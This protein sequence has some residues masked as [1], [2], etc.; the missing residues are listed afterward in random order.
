[1]REYDCIVIGGGITGAGAVRDAALRGLKVLLI[2]KGEL[3]CG[4]TASSS[5]LLH[6][7][8]RYLAYDRTTTQM[9]CWDSGNILRIARSL[10]QRQVFLWPVYRHHKHRME[11]VESLLEAYDLLQP[12]KEGKKHLRLDAPATLSILPGL[13]SQG[14]LGSLTFDEWW[15][16]PL[17]LVRQ[18]VASAQKY[19]AEV[20]THTQVL[21]LL[22]E[23]HRI[24][25][26]Q[27]Q[28]ENSAGTENVYA[29]VLINATG[30]W[31]QKICAL[32]GVKVP[33]RLRKGVHLI[34][35]GLLVP[36]GVLLEAVDRVRYVFLIPIGGMTLLGPTDDPFEEDPDLLEVSREEIRYLLDSA[37]R[38]FPHLPEN[39][40]STTIGVRPI[41]Y[42]P[43]SERFLSRDHAVLDHEKLNGVR[44]LISITGGK[45]STYRQMAED[46][47]D[48]ACEKLGR[49]LPCRTHLETLEGKTIQLSPLTT[50]PQLRPQKDTATWG[51]WSARR[52][53]QKR[54]EAG[55]SLGYYALKHWVRNLSRPPSLAGPEE[56]RRHY[57]LPTP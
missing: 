23:A 39:F 15:M 27:V 4:T 40:Q 1:M 42:Q 48:L 12:L 11:T 43:G 25:G 34:F 9:S 49:R 3:G 6:G 51:R 41:L 24:G 17:Q 53:L 18:T 45:L 19:G 57:D 22:G 10:F 37:K 13:N 47:V 55:I 26:V 44:G 7:G 50:H 8:L 29:R 20:W 36:H 46:A 14:L 28:R 2:E 33:M 21:G 38:Y 56:S 31:T 5:R 35:P 32:A 52:G 16:D 54:I 30:A